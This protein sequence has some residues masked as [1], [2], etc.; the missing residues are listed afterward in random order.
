MYAQY[1]IVAARFE[2]QVRINSTGCI[3]RY[4]G[5][6]NPDDVVRISLTDKTIGI[7][8]VRQCLVRILVTRIARF[9]GLVIDATQRGQLDARHGDRCVDASPDLIHHFHADVRGVIGLENIREVSIVIE[10]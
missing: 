10:R 6:V 5:V 3:D 7:C 1:K 2:L 8:G 9:E 4:H